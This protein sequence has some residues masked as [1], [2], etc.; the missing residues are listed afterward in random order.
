MV[1]LIRVLVLVVALLG[2]PDSSV[3]SEEDVGRLL[4][5]VAA[6]ESSGNC[7]AVAKLSTAIGCF[8]MT[9]AALQDAGFKDADGWIPNEYGITSDEEFMANPEANYAAMLE[10]TKANWR[11]LFCDAKAMICGVVSDFRLDAAA[12]LAGAHILGAKGISRFLSCDLDP[13]CLS[14]KAVEVNRVGRDGL[15][16]IVVGRMRDVAAENLDVSEL[17]QDNPRGC[18]VPGPCQ[19]ALGERP[20]VVPRG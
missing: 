19:S 13:R 10:Y 16:N 12:L 5:I 9:D 18:D 6:R 7:A 17:T 4:Q 2:V 3:A 15:A 11:A 14:D 20:R 1:T 8:Q